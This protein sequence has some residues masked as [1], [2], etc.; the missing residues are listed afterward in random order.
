MKVCFHWQWGWMVA[1]SISALT[2]ID[3]CMNTPMC[4]LGYC[5]ICRCL[6]SELTSDCQFYW[7]IDILSFF[8]NHVSLK[9][10]IYKKEIQQAKIYSA[11]KQV[12][13]V[14]KLP[15]TAVYVFLL[16]TDC[17]LLLSLWADGN[18]WHIDMHSCESI[19]ND[20]YTVIS[21]FIFNT[22]Q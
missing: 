17:R 9:N 13:T 20:V 1:I 10:Q 11:T 6:P 8:F 18:W 4:C 7:D 19:I 2:Y 16:F 14:T 3:I 5:P 15:V 21:T 12:K 22:I